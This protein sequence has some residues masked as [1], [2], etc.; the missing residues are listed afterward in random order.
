MDA[1]QGQGAA[2]APH[3]GSAQPGPKPHR[4]RQRMHCD[5]P[6]VLRTRACGVAPGVD[7]P[8]PGGVGGEGASRTDD[9][10]VPG[11]W[12]AVHSHCSERTRT[13]ILKSF[14]RSARCPPH[15]I[16][17]KH[18]LT[19]GD[20]AWIGWGWS[21]PELHDHYGLP[22]AENFDVDYG[23]KASAPCA[24]SAASPGVFTRKYPK[25]TITWDCH[26]GRGSIEMTRM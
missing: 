8:P 12:L 24:E 2:S 19:R 13:T 10:G 11:K 22:R 6:R 25:A 21:H 14:A 26:A 20:Y 5:S 23:G 7:V 3:A 15:C 1:D 17:P 16:I 4:E 9:C 18:Q